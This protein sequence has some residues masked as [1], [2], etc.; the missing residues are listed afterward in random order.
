[1]KKIIYLYEKL[2]SVEW[3]QMQSQKRKPLKK[4]V[5]GEFDEGAGVNNLIET[6]LRSFLKSE[7]NYGL[8]T[9][10]RTDVNNVFR[11]VK[12]LIAEKNLNIYALK[13]RDEIYLSK[14]V[15]HF[16]ELY[17]VVRERSQLK[18]KKGIVEIWDDSDNK[19]LHFFVPSLRRHLPIEYE[20]E[21]E[22]KEIME[23][24]LEAHLD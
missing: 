8:I 9:D 12:E 13:V 4:S 23:N 11:L 22:K 19:I 2:I 3:T 5:E 15:E 1:L 14:A 6:L 24:L 10:I 7:S 18:I 20:S 17:K 16:N 21:H